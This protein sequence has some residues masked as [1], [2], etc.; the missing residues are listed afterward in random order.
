MRLR[1]DVCH[2]THVN[3]TL[4]RPAFLPAIVAAIAAVV[5]GGVIAAGAA[6]RAWGPVRE[7]PDDVLRVAWTQ[8]LDAVSVTEDGEVAGTVVVSKRDA[9]APIATRVQYHRVRTR[10]GEEAQSDTASTI[11]A[12]LPGVGALT[13]TL[14][15]R[16]VGTQQYLRLDAARID[17]ASDGDASSFPLL[18]AAIQ[19]VIGGRWMLVDAAGLAAIGQVISA[20]EPAPDDETVGTGDG[21]AL[22][23]TFATM[24]LFRTAEYLGADRVDGDRALHYRARFNPDIVR[25]YLRA[26]STRDVRTTKQITAALAFTEAQ[27][28][29]AMEAIV[30]DVW[31]TRRGYALR[32]VSFPFHVTDPNSG[33]DVRGTADLRWSGW[34]GP[35]TVE[36]PTDAVPIAELLGPFLRGRGS[37]VLTPDG[38]AALDADHDGLTNTLE[39]V[40]GSDPARSDTDGDGYDDGAEVEN[41]YSPIGTGRLPVR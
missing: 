13:A 37:T 36:Q 31:V 7:V 10:A 32:R 23:A 2:A 15:S 11:A 3:V 29:P 33:A 35:V 38:A 41:G 26:A 17:P 39:R 21:S 5:V 20:V 6:W 9:V 30:A 25:A 27:I 1:G 19:G 16:T 22:R 40:Y 14:A 18:V 24:P 12:T 28:V 4:H 8:A 34:N